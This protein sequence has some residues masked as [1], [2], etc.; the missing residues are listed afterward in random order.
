MPRTK[1]QF[2]ILRQGSRK[3]ILE[4]ALEVFARDGYKTATIGSIAK[5]AGISQGLL[6]NYFKSK[7]DVLH[8]LLLGMLEEMI[9]E[10][11]ML[12]PG[13]KITREDMIEFINRSIDLVLEKPQFW[14]LYFSIFIQPEVLAML[15]AEL[16]KLSEPFIKMFTN[17]FKEKGE[18]NPVLMAQYFTA[19]VDGVQM[20]CML[21]PDSYPV[22][23]IKK[24]LIKQFA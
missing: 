24:L 14:K 21:E 22:N 4:A 8:E 9:V 10:F 5:T 19:V 11:D 15:Y 2:E 3:K 1:E 17:Y 20:H 6:Y 23:E 18:R 16:M 13:E 12:K 7:E